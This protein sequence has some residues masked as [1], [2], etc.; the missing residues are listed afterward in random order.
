MK[1]VEYTSADSKHPLCFVSSFADLC[2]FLAG[3]TSISIPAYSLQ[4]DPRYFYPFDA[5]FWPDRWLDPKERK[6]FGDATKPFVDHDQ[7]VHN[8]AAFIPFSTGPRICPG[9]NIAM[10][11]MQIVAACIM[12]NFDL[13][14]VEGYDIDEWEKHL[15]DLFIVTKGPLPLVLVERG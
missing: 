9:K 1:V 12:R 14:A 13:K 2:S 8:T 3:G 5:S 11:E 4:R 6:V 7:V 10:I 15:G